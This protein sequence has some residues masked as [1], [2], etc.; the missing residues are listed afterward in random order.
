[1]KSMKSLKDRKLQTTSGSSLFPV[2]EVFSNRMLLDLMQPQGSPDCVGPTLGFNPNSEIE[3][4]IS[5]RRGFQLPL[6]MDEGKVRGAFSRTRL[7]LSGGQDNF[8]G[9]FSRT[10]FWGA[11]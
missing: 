7:P 8:R 1:M 3:R 6:L 5:G 4:R 2:G 11:H 9:A 10:R